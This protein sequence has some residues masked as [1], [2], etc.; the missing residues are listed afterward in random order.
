MTRCVA[1]TGQSSERRGSTQGRAMAALSAGSRARAAAPAR[2][3]A[4]ASPR[5]AAPRRAAGTY[6]ARAARPPRPGRPGRGS[7]TS[8]SP[9][10][11][12]RGCVAPSD[13]AATIP[14]CR[15]RPRAIDPRGAALA[16]SRAG[17]KRTLS[18]G[19]CCRRR[20]SPAPLAAAWRAPRLWIPPRG[21]R[22]H[23]SGGTCPPKERR[24]NP[25]LHQPPPRLETQ[26]LPSARWTLRVRPLFRDFSLFGQVH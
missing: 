26:S 11:A 22:T 21:H 10:A 3:A 19:C 9:L 20:G 17:A 14:V 18:R 6:A 16:S 13:G 7:G 5:R 8:L 12:T 4:S 25:T 1:C 15:L 23:V 2:L 24:S